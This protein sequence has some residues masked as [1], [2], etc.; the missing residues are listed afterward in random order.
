MLL[1]DY[2]LA[3][4]KGVII[5]DNLIVTWE[6][7]EWVKKTSLNFKGVIPQ[8]L[9]LRMIKSLTEIQKGILSLVM[10]NLLGFGTWFNRAVSAL[11]PIASARICMNENLSKRISL[12]RSNMQGCPSVPYLYFISEKALGHLWK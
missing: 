11:V 4:L 12:Q 3:S 2:Q 1:M 9:I 7:I 6:N 8:N 10:I 5:L